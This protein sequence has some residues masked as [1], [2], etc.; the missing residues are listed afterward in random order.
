MAKKEKLLGMVLKYLAQDIE[1][2]CFDKNDLKKPNF[3]FVRSN[4]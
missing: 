4:N 1:I 2:K 3:V